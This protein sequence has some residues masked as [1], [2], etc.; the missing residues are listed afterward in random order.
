MNTVTDEC[1]KC[2]SPTMRIDEN[3]AQ[4]VNSDCRHTQ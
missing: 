2:G 1:M 3:T 4:C